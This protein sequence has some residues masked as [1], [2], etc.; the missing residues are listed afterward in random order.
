MRINNNNPIE[1][2][3]REQD[4]AINDVYTKLNGLGIYKNTVINHESLNLDGSRVRV[5]YSNNVEF[6]IDYNTCF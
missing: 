4:D 3:E 1:N 6:T 5:T 2:R